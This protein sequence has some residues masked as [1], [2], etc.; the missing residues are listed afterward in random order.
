MPLPTC[1]G[2]CLSH[3][4]FLKGWAKHQNEEDS[5]N[6]ANNDFVDNAT[7]TLK[8][9]NINT[10]IHIFLSLLADNQQQLLFSQNIFVLFLPN[11]CL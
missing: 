6:D 5:N 8:A 7:A 10:Y 11:F 4:I 1:L 9:K 2:V 3:P